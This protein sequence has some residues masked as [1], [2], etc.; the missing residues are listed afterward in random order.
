MA[1][2][3]ENM[4]RDSSLINIRKLAALDIVFHGP[5]LILA[6]FGY[7]VLISAGLGLFMLYKGIF[8]GHFHSLFP[9]I[10]GGC[11]S[12]LALNYLL[13]LL[14]AIDIV[15]HKSAQDEV[16]FELAHKDTYARKYTWQS[17]LLVLPLVVPL[18]ALV[19][20][21]RRRR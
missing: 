17:L 16:A 20:E 14:Y 6:E 12:D 15:R 7:T 10:F 21:V 5:K 13:L 1:L 9:V 2:Q 3:N 4:V 11:L 18:M 19:Q 8:L